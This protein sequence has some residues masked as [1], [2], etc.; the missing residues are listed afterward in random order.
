MYLNLQPCKKSVNKDP[1]DLQ[2]KFEKRLL[3]V[4]FKWQRIFALK[5][6]YF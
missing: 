4:K 3:I 2:N 5:L 1:K 6:D